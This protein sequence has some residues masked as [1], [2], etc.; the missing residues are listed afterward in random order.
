M[1]PE[2]EELIEK[3]FSNSLNNEETLLFEKLLQNDYDFKEEFLFQKDL[4][5]ALERQQRAEIKAGLQELEKSYSKKRVIPLK[6]WLLAA[7]IA[8]LFGLGYTFYHNYKT[9]QPDYL[10]TSNFEPYR[11]VVK[12][13]ERGAT[14]E[15]IETKAFSAYENKAYYKAINLF[16]SIQPKDQEYVQFYKAMSYLSLHKNEEAI[17]LLLPLATRPDK[18]DALFK[19]NAKANWYLALAY[20]GDDQIEKA[21]SQFLVVVSNPDCV[22]KK[23]EAKAILAKLQA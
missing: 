20:L 9:Q 14:S 4:K 7:S 12:P 23:E 6:K 22:Y 5:K 2:Q 13:I 8:L 17:E 10:F 11:N 15:D 1:N 18:A 19:W 21:I 16:N 3:Y